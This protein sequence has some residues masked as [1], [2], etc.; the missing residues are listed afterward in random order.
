[1]YVPISAEPS[2]PVL[3]FAFLL[4]LVT[5]IT[6]GA[7]PAWFNSRVQPAEALRGAGRGRAERRSLV[8]RSLVVMQVALSAILLVGGGLL[9]RSLRNLERQEFGFEPQ[10]R[11]IVRVDPALAGYTPE[12]LYG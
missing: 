3:G 8:R 4:S 9:T 12:K 1:Q 11:L 2:V 10:G 5:G 6:F 7:A